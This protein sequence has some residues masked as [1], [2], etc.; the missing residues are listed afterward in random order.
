MDTPQVLLEHYL[1]QLRLPTMLRELPKMADQCAR[2]GATFEQFLFRLVE[3]WVILTG[4]G[5]VVERCE[6]VRVV[7]TGGS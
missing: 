1:K 2:E 3:Q 7:S 6:W 5:G 4:A